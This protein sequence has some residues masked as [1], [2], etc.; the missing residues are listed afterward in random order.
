MIFT[1]KTGYNGLFRVNGKGKFNVPHGRHTNPKISDDDNLRACSK[2]L[3]GVLVLTGDFLD[4]AMSAQRGDF[5]YFDPPYVPVTATSD[6]T[7]Y[8]KDKFGPAEQERLRD[9]AWLLK[10]RG[11]HVVLSNADAPLVRQLYKDFT[12]H[13]VLAKR[14][15]NSDGAKRGKVAE[16]IIV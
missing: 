1:N 11:V 12:I 7:S 4:Y 9:A 16:V 15:I 10:Q 3:Q 2:A 5:V 8:T 14:N 6:F 13:S